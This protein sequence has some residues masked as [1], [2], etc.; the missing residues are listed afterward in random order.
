[1]VDGPELGLGMPEEEEDVLG[2]LG[3][4]EGGGARSEEATK[5]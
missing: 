4:R 2:G 1:M 3:E 5:G